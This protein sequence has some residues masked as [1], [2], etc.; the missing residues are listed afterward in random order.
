ML[1]IPYDKGWRIE[2]NGK[3]VTAD[4]DRTFT[5]LTMN[6]GENKI[7]MKYISPG[8]REG[9]IISLLAILLF[10]IWQRAGKEKNDEILWGGAYLTDDL[11]VFCFCIYLI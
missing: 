5:V 10:V 11:L 4:A 6:K 7:T 9:A 8:F 3:T 1:T 2:C